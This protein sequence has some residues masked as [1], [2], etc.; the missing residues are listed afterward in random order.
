MNLTDLE[1]AKYE[2]LVAAV[3]AYRDFSP[4]ESWLPVFSELVGD[5]RG[6]VLDA[7][8]CT[9]KGG[10][11]LS[12]RGFDVTLCDLTDAGLV[13][14]AR[15]LEFRSVC[16]WQGLEPL[17][18]RYSDSGTCFDYVI[19]CDVLEHIPTE[20]TMLV[21]RNLLA[22]TRHGLFLTICFHADEFGAAIGEALHLTVQSFSWWKTRIS[23]LGEIVDARDLI[24][25]GTFYVRPRG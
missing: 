12:A 11:W 20:Y 6:T 22:V 17:A 13:E 14:E 9:G 5:S 15:R 3:P 16:L 10:L 1:R 24:N 18:Y 8:C 25:I 2:T 7:G 19:A 4:A 23:E 21:L